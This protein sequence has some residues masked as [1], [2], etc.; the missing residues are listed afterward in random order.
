MNSPSD[1][2][3]NQFP[4]D[5]ATYLFYFATNLV[6]I[7]AKSNEKARRPRAILTFKMKL[8]CY[9][10]WG[11]AGSTS[12]SS[13]SG[14]LSSNGLFSR[15]LAAMGCGMNWNRGQDQRSA[16]RLSTFLLGAIACNV[17]MPLGS[18]FL[19]PIIRH[20][21]CRAFR[22]YLYLKIF[23]HL[24]DNLWSKVQMRIK[25]VYS[26]KYSK[27]MNEINQNTFTIHIKLHKLRKITYTLILPGAKHNAHMD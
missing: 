14:P 1:R 9:L 17:T 10:R 18:F 19:K 7:S 16:T 26:S 21:Q 8:K 23:L 24:V 27:W 15:T 5:F 6:P 11:W 20:F 25:T 22:W 2:F 13:S 12:S 3:T 4:A